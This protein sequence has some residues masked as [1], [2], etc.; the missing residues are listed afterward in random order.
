[1][2]ELWQDQFMVALDVVTGK[3]VWE[4]PLVIEP[5]VA[6]CYMACAEGHIVV[7][8]SAKGK[9]HVYVYD[10]DSG[11][12]QWKQT[13]S[14]G[15]GGRS[16]HGSHLSRPVI[17]DGTLYVSPK[18]FNLEDGEI[19]PISLPTANC[20]SYSACA[21]SLIFRVKPVTRMWNR[22][23]G[24]LSGWSLLRPNCWISTIPANGMILSLEGG[25]GCSC[26]GW[27]ETSFGYMPKSVR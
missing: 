12:T 25:G 22:A 10:A 27:I 24:K 16:D 6:V 18:V 14:W 15:R 1:M 9:Y 13:F 26:G 20:G 4:K 8:S 2:A 17:V 21:N 11:T 3:V 7:V 5:A 23:S 19:L